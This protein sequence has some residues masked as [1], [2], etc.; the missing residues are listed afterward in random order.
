MLSMN[1][2]AANPASPRG[3]GF[4]GAQ[5]AIRP[6]G[7]AAGAGATSAS[8]RGILAASICASYSIVDESGGTFVCRSPCGNEHIGERQKQRR[9]RSITRDDR[10]PPSAPQPWPP[11][12]GGDQGRL[13]RGA[14]RRSAEKSDGEDHRSEALR[15]AA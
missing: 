15:T 12:V 3:A 13:G 4:A 11:R 6:G 14:T 10:R 1:V 5:P 8:R 9:E 2:V 7:S